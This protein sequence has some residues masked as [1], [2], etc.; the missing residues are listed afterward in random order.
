MALLLHATAKALH[1]D[2]CPRRARRRAAASGAEALAAP[3]PTA[4]ND[5]SAAHARHARAK[6]VVALAANVRRLKWTFHDVLLTV[7]S[8]NAP[9]RA[10]VQH[11]DRRGDKQHARKTQVHAV[12]K[13]IEKRRCQ[14]TSRARAIKVAQKSLSSPGFPIA[15]SM[16]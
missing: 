11:A 12:E 9:P 5:V 2:A 6:A 3:G 10:A 16:E 15:R 1:K 13:F 8:T 14:S 7:L 4:T